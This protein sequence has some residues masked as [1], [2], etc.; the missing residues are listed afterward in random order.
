MCPMWD[1]DIIYGGEQL[2]PNVTMDTLE[3]VLWDC[4][5]VAE[6]VQTSLG[7][8]G[9]KVEVVVSAIVDGAATEAVKLG[10]FATSIVGKVRQKE[11][12]DLPAV[13]IFSKVPPKDASKQEALVMSFRRPWGGNRPDPL[14]TITVVRNSGM[15]GISAPAQSSAEPV[16][17]LEG[18]R[19]YHVLQGRKVMG[20]VIPSKELHKLRVAA[21]KAGKLKD[22][23]DGTFSEDIPF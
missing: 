13:I 21:I 23:G 6:N 3:Y 20:D 19:W 9:T 12:G 1:N 22:N 8:D 15:H 11:E 7:N 5:V 4:A 2:E 16:A 14:P 18:G 10:T 17:D